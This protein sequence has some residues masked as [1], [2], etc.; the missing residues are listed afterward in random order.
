MVMQ[1]TRA[2]MPQQMRIVFGQNLSFRNF[3]KNAPDAAHVQS[4]YFVIWTDAKKESI[5]VEFHDGQQCDPDRQ[6][7]PNRGVSVLTEDHQ[8]LFPAFAADQKRIR[9]AEVINVDA[10]QF[11]KL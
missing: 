2:R 8:A 1:M 9:I 6:P 5:R 10:A 4:L 11:G 3:D 7:N